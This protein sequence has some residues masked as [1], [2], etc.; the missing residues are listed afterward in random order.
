MKTRQHIQVFLLFLS[1]SVAHA[2]EG[3]NPDAEYGFG[4]TGGFVTGSGIYL[5]KYS[6][7]NYVQVGGLASGFVKGDKYHKG[8]HDWNI[9]AVVG[10]YLNRTYYKGAGLPVGFQMFFGIQNFYE[11]QVATQILNEEIW[12]DIYVGPGFGVDFFNPATK[13]FGIWLTFSYAAQ[14]DMT[15]D[16]YEPQST[17]FWGST[18]ASYNW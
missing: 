13:G 11:K 15:L 2:H 10:R 4:L 17:S 6:G 9:A 12:H 1:L 3:M 7:V 8:Q 18:G 14:F 5:R 16:T